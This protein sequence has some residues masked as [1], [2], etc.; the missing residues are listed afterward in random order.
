M[1]RWF[2]SAVALLLTFVCFTNE[3]AF[4]QFADRAII[5]G[6]VTDASGAAIPDARVTITDTQTGVKTVVGTNS[7]GNYS[8]PPLILGTYRVEVEKQGFKTFS[9]PGYSLTGGQTV[10]VDAKLERWSDFGD[11]TGGSFHHRT[12]EH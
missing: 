5:T 12:R 9:R 2:L 4:A 6:V 1:K 10:R 3:H 11:R 8:T 7:A